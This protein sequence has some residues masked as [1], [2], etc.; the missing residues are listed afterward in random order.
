MRRYEWTLLTE[1]TG[2]K[3][4]SRKTESSVKDK[5][6]KSKLKLLPNKEK[7]RRPE[8]VAR[9]IKHINKKQVV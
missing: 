1:I 5:L 9:R 8:E 7:Q 3:P 4:T 2:N 6:T